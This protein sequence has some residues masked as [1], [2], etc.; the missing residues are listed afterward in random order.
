[1]SEPYRPSNGS[2]G[3]C[4]YE[5]WCMHCAND[6]PMS[7]GKDFDECGPEEVCTIIAETLAYDIGDPKYPIEWIRDE[8]GARCTAFVEAGSHVPRRR[9][10][11][12]AELFHV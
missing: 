1:M 10:E 4:F 12:T 8:T 7:E 3:E 9:C 6:K 2:E 5:A 11:R